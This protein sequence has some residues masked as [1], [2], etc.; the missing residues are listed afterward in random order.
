MSSLSTIIN[1]LKFIGL[2]KSLRTI[3]YAIYRDR[4]ERLNR[5]FNR[6]TKQPLAN[7]GR[8]VGCQREGMHV[9]FQFEAYDL[10]VAVLADNLFRLTWQP[11]KLPVDYAISQ[12]SWDPVEFTLIHSGTDNLINTSDVS[13]NITANGSLILT[14]SNGR[15]L[16]RELP[17]R[18]SQ[19][20]WEHIADLNPVEA[21]Y[22]I[23]LRSAGLN[24][25][26]GTYRVWN[27]D[28]GGK[29]T[30]GNDPLY[31]NVPVFT[32]ISPFGNYLV[33]YEN[34][35]EGQFEFDQQARVAF[36]DGALRYYL[37]TGSLP[38]LLST[39]TQLTGRPPLPP[40]WSLGYHQSR[41]GYTHAQQVKEIADKFR[42]HDLPLDAIHLDIDYM[43]GYRVFTVDPDRF[44]DLKKLSADLACQNVRLVT[45]IDPGVKVDPEYALFQEGLQRGFFIKSPHGEPTKALVWPEWCAFPDF[46]DPTVRDWWAVH[47]RILVDQGVAGVWHDMNE[48]GTF[49]AWGEPTLPNNARHAL[50]GRSG[51]HSEAH[52]L[53]GLMMNKAG[54][55]GLQKAHP[56]RRPW[57]LTRSGWAGVQRYA[58]NWTADVDSSWTMLQQTIPALLNLSMS[59]LYFAGS[60]IG[61][62][63]GHP[64]RELYLRWFQLATFTPFFRLHCAMGLPAREP[65][66]Y[67]PEVIDIVRQFLLLRRQLLPYLYTLAYQAASEG[68]PLMRP[69]AW[70]CPDDPDVYDIED[71]FLLGDRILVAPV[72]SSGIENR[73]IWLP[74]GEWIDFWT[75]SAY[76]GPG[77]AKIETSL[78]QIPLLIKSGHLLPLEHD[79]ELILLVFLPT[80]KIGST[81]ENTDLIY[82]D[83]GDGYGPSRI[84]S[85]HISIQADWFSINRTTSGEYEWP[86]QS[87]RFKFIGRRVKEISADGMKI[88]VIENSISLKHMHFLQGLTQ[89]MQAGS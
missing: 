50:D 77:I 45:I 71:Q 69:M 11:G 48:P 55:D 75:H 24:L 15:Q 64:G 58:W 16:R 89:T 21:I 3:Q 51:D 49:S 57:L 29:Y 56:D 67:D 59:G 34:S 72:L 66:Q 36:P 30:R 43:S 80:K 81:L 74:S 37:I 41:W 70:E 6:G 2:K 1:A 38:Q 14:D 83:V 65:W 47:Y 12:H 39:Y 26:G 61:G 5:S 78:Q 86:Y 18:L 82:S 54:F 20:G 8:M 28:P 22:G 62:F 35:H 84:D 7:P 87:I 79:D 19:H 23:G 76:S 25:R 42:Q 88:P 31:L 9:N 52:N 32:A 17:P 63:N 40:R 68:R 53:Y 4:Q 27:T 13:L 10:E 85:F 73:S 44:P 33:F 46:T 60:D